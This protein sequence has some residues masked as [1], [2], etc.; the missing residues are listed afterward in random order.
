[1]TTLLLRGGI[2]PD[3]EPL[4]VRTDP[5]TGTVVSVRRELPPI[6]GSR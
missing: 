1:M 3:S 6:P 5:R 4:E 2:G